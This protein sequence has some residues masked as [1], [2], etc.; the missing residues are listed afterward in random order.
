MKTFQWAL[1]LIFLSLLSSLQAAEFTV[2]REDDP[3][4]DACVPGDCSLREAVIAANVSVDGDNIITVPAGTYVLTQPGADEDAA[5]TG[6]LDLI[7]P[8]LNQVNI[9]STS[10][11]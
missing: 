1:S 2:S 7:Y 8:E 11:I 3:V 10:T 4:P 9:P 6:D 5:Q